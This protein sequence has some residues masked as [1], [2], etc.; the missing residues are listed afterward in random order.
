MRIG[1]CPHPRPGLEPGGEWPLPGPA[2]AREAP[3]PALE[4]LLERHS[5]RVPAGTGAPAAGDLGCL[6]APPPRTPS[7]QR[8]LACPGSH[9]AG[10]LL[11]VVGCVGRAVGRIAAALG[12]LVADGGRRLLDA[13]QSLT[14]IGLELGRTTLASVARGAGAPSTLP[15]R[16]AEAVCNAA[17]LAGG[18]LLSAVQTL[19]HLERPGR[20]LNSVELAAARQ[21]FGGAVDLSRVRVKEGFAGLGSVNAR[22]FTFGET[23]YLKRDSSLRTLIHELVHVWQD[24]HGPVPL[25]ASL[26]AQRS[27]HAYDWRRGVQEGRAWRALNPEQQAQL[28]EDAYIAGQLEAAPQQGGAREADHASRYVANALRELRAGR[29]S[30]ASLR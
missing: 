20:R 14:G 15:L 16:L 18:G 17:L 1:T 5:A 9:S 13:T 4:H 8:S 11:R 7:G 26:V 29:G 3:P 25:F 21:V 27:E 22:P 10:G 23:I 12:S 2:P 24:Q 6:A 19:L 30:G 28:V